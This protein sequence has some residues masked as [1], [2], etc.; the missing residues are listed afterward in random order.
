MLNYTDG[1]SVPFS[2]TQP[3]VTDHILLSVN[4][5]IVD[6]RVVFV[7]S[8]TMSQT[9]PIQLHLLG[10]FSLIVEGN[11][12]TLRRKTR[13]LLA[14]LATT[15]Q[16]HARQ[17]LVNLF[18]Q[19]A[20]APNRALAVLLSRVRQ[21]LGS[22]ALL[23][24]GERVQLNLAQVA[25]DVTQFVGILE[26]NLAQQTVA[27]LET[28]VS[29][30]RADFLAGL[31]L[32]D[33]PEFE[34]WLLAQQARLRHL[35]ER[36]LLQLISQ[37]GA[38]PT[39]ALSYA[40]QLVQHSPLLE[41][42]QAQLMAL[43]AQLGQREAAL[44][45]YDHCH[46]L[47][48]TELAVEP[49]P[50]LQRLYTQIKAGQLGQLATAVPQPDLNHMQPETADFVGRT[51]E[52]ARLHAAWRKASAGQGQMVLLCAPAGGGKSRLMQQFRQG[53]SPVNVY[54]G[55]CYESTRL[56]P[57]Q[58][59]LPILEAHL[60]QLDDAAL[61][62]LPPATQTYLSRLLPALARRLSATAVS[63]ASVV[64]EPERLFTAVVDF[65]SQMPSSQPTAC[66]MLLDDLQWADETS[67][68]LL[69]YVVQRLDRFPW[70]L[71][72]AY[73]PEEADEQ[74]VLRLLLDE[75][76]RRGVPRLRL[77]PLAQAE[78]VRLTAHLWPQLAPGYRKHVAAM[79]AEA[80]GGNALFVTAV[81]QELASS[82]H[83]PSELPVPATVQDLMQR[84]L[85]RLSS[86]GRQ[87]LEALAL[88]DG[89][90][91]LR[92]LQQ[93][94]ARS[95]LETEQAL[96]WGLQWGM[97]TV[98]TPA[99]RANAATVVEEAV[100]PTTY[101]FLH[102]LVREAVYA[103]LS[104]VRRQR[105]HRR[106][107]VWLARVARR[108][109][110]PQQQEAA[111]PILVH[112]Q[113]GE[114]FDLIFQW[115]ALAA[116]HHRQIF[117]Y[118]DA[119]RALDAMRAAYPQFQ[120]LP[121]F[122]PA[123]AEPALFEALLAW[124]SHAWVLGRSVEE[125][126]AVFQL[127][128]TL[129]KRH[130]SPKRAAQLQLIRAQIGL[131]YAKAIPVLEAAH[132]QFLQLNERS[133]AAQALITAASAS[134]TMSHNRDGRSLYEQALTLYRQN[135]DEAGEVS[136]L[137]G[138]AWTALNLGETAVALQHLQRALAISR[139]QGDKLGEAQ[140]LYGLAAAWAF[141]HAPEQMTT[142]AQEAKQVYEQIGFAG[143]AIRPLLY[144]GAAHGIRGEW[145]EALAIYE[146]T[147][148][149]ALAF[150]DGWVAGWLAQLAGRI[151]LQ[152]GELA[153][154]EA[155]LQQAQQLRL[156]SGERQ[157][158]VSDL[159]WL[160]R[161]HVQR[162]EL[163]TALAQTAQA[164]SQLEA[165]AGEFYVW[166]QP[167]VLL[168]RAEVLAVARQPADARE[169]AQQAHTCLH[170]FAQ[171]ITDPAVLA[172]FLAYPLNVRVET[173]VATNRIA[174]WPEE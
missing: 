174:P 116:A 94:S 102:D 123:E 131:D 80:T 10:T 101:H 171:Q 74:P 166:E 103:T 72:A 167:D 172:Q 95:E 61:E 17:A 50:E 27:E 122:D 104:P 126:Q 87:V 170:Q 157:N 89:G 34:Q 109:P 51:A 70:L 130:P 149:K 4:R 99:L 73:R 47:L 97:V 117:A 159:V 168:C 53:L 23:S 136:C 115:S 52:M 39:A 125:E 141:Y 16:P 163:D 3:E 107:A 56:L 120:L 75:F 145:D 108:R 29:L 60:Q 40:Q 68:R 33:A 153:A 66:L 63:S 67:L 169:V 28:A 134:I 36:G 1:Q 92:Q 154:A 128:Q 2:I 85:Q 144:L 146:A 7:K 151:Y 86:G 49:T 150:E 135:D 96:E 37:L 54:V 35:L 21:K 114:A 147:L 152:R 65:L 64:D 15:G 41:E 32:D 30:Y 100:S 55:T 148:P 57:Y 19:E 8:S 82:D 45:Q 71:L 127:A 59:W 79:L 22:S 58:P 24:E 140:A 111:G 26:G 138:L 43:Y 93:I 124:L 121:N 88:L 143:R 98:D 42:G 156:A 46:T 132:Q 18:C 31:T 5:I 6:S 91:T 11:T 106:T 165:F 155:K 118:R 81:L 25:V 20:K 139:A 76:T 142:L 12:P 13:A 77:A 69:H 113:Q 119:L 161:L 90:G 160:A 44:R 158:Q 78:V 162:G 9:A 83:I 62:E 110:L 164:V 105:L 129:S 112:A 84:R 48:Q 133:L 137:A 14:Y 38:Q 173:A